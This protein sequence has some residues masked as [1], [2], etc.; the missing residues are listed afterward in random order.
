MVDDDVGVQDAILGA[1]QRAGH[2]ATRASDSGEAIQRARSL[3]FDLAIVDLRLPGPD[4]IATFRALRRERPT[5]AGILI[6]AFP[7]YPSGVVEAIR[8][9]FS[10]YF[11]KPFRQADLMKHVEAALATRGLEHDAVRQS[12]RAASEVF[13]GMIGTTARMRD[14]FEV[15]TRIAETEE[16]VLIS[17]ETGTGKELVARAIHSRSARSG[18]P[19]RTLNCAAAGPDSL[20]ESELFG[21]ERGAFTGA[22]ERVTGWLEESRGGTLFLDEVSELSPA[23]QAKLLRAIEYHEIARLGSRQ[24]IRVDVRILAATNVDLFGPSIPFRQDLFHRL[25]ALEIRLPSLRERLDDLPALVGH[26]LPL[27]AAALR[28]S[29]P[30]VSKKVIDALCGYSWPGNIRELQQELKKACLRCPSAMLTVE[31]LSDHLR[32]PVQIGSIPDKRADSGQTARTLHDARR[33]A[34]QASVIDAL[35]RTD[36]DVAAAAKLL[37]VSRRTV[38]RLRSLK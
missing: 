33:E 15:I 14:L 2:D 29:T 8:D 35:A 1:L 28:R 6:T 17:G 37:G 38:E 10:D 4:G 18:R 23:A 20:L 16:A 32:H 34:E 26:F 30:F 11:E 21:H 7:V 19:L 25:S 5:L 27:V 36:G 31:H 24:A 22:T 13:D 3:P 9:G 12:K